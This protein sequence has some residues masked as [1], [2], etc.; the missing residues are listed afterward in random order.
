MKTLKWAIIIGI[1]LLPAISYPSTL[2]SLRISLV[3]GDIQVRT[4]NT[5]EW[6]PASINM[7]LADGDRIWVP[8]GGRTEVQLRDGTFLRLDE[9]SALEILRIENDSFQFYLSEGRSYANFSGLRGS[10]LQI[11][12]LVSSVRAYD[13]S[14]FRIDITED[15]YRD[16]SVYKGDIYAES[17]EGRTR[18]VAGK[19]LSLREGTYAE[20]FPLDPPDEW[21]RWNTER[22]RRLAARKPPPRYLPEE[23]YPYAYDFEENGR[24][25]YAREYGYVWRPTAV[26]SVGWSPY[27]IGRWVWLGGDYVWISYEHWGWIPYHYGRWAFVASIGWCWVPPVRGAVYWGPGFVGWIYT[28]SYVSWVPLAP[29]EIYYGYGY[30]GPHSVNITQVNITHIDVHRVVYKNVR[31]QNAVTVIRRDTF[32]TGKHAEVQLRENPFLKEKINVGR[33]DIKPE[34]ATIMPVIKEIPQTKN[35][36]QPIRE[37]RVNELKER[38]PLVRKKEISVL[39]PESPPKEMELKIKEGKPVEREI[40]KF[41]DR[42]PAERGLERPREIRTL[43]RKAQK[44]ESMEKIDRKAKEIKPPEKVTAGKAK[45]V[46]SSEKEALERPKE[47]RSTERG[48]DKSKEFRPTEKSVEK[49][50]PAEKREGRTKEI[51]SPEKTPTEKTKEIRPLGNEEVERPKEFRSIQK[52]SEKFR[53]S[54]P[55]EKGVEKLGPVE[56]ELEKS[57]ELKQIEEEAEKHQEFKQMEKRKR[58]PDS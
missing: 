9:N 31:V 7:P 8:E 35:P 56:G 50:E 25:V 13:R 21:E 6:V 41:D 55:P 30:Y 47:F 49:L 52:G 5:G 36:P 40:D 28:P 15:G 14:N 20:L 22:D 18:V 44:P 33:P 45:E 24:W 48:V 46:K 12:T 43:H 10:L 51:K 37:I 58:K 29:R 11:D 16:I 39:R 54:R 4:E 34:K 1:L 2:G 3:E 17:M 38:R 26:V 53:E 32:I 23:L 27:R 19:V 57:G 42:R